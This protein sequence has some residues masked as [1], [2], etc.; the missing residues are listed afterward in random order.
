MTQRGA[1]GALIAALAAGLTLGGFGASAYSAE[2]P[3]ESVA[4]SSSSSGSSKIIAQDLSSTITAVP[5]AVGS[6]TVTA[7]PGAKV[8]GAGKGLRSTKV[9][10][11]GGQVVFTKLT[12]GAVYTFTSQGE[13][14]S[15][16]AMETVGAA[17]NLKVFTTDG[18][19][20]SDSVLL[21]W[22]HRGT[23]ARGADAIRYLITATPVTTVPIDTKAA[24]PRVVTA[25]TSFTDYTLT[26]LNPDA[27]YTF[28]VTPSN[29]IGTGRSTSAT[30]SESLRTLT[31]GSVPTAPQP[32]AESP[33]QPA[34]PAVTPA[35]PAPAPAPQPAPR[36][37]TRTIYVCPDG[38]SEA[39]DLCE[40]V[41]PYTYH[42]VTE[43]RG[44]SYHEEFVVTGWRVDPYPCSSGT[45]HPDGCH[46]PLGYTTTVKD[47]PPAGWTDSGSGYQRTVE[48]KDALP[49][50]YSDNGSAWVKVTAKVAREVAA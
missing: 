13:R 49:A 15:A 5:T 22:Q 32:A 34:Q 45:A 11:K 26:G 39:G 31:G 48:V 3:P 47:A 4:T 7:Q 38:Y 46:V 28:T 50:G 14:T 6:I 41:A 43:T 44:Y 30:M 25:E 1:R 8:T 16:R 10:N 18:A 35:A 19:H 42:S 24:Q 27:T 9:A 33:R 17:S 29:P 40:Q 23:A 12:P 37:A 20:K 36:P 2:L 21:T